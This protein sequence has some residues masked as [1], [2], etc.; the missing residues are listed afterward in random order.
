MARRS[1]PRLSPAQ[2]EGKE[3]TLAAAV[4]RWLEG[5][6]W[7]VYQEVQLALP[8][9]T[10]DRVADIIALKGD[11]VWGIECKV[12]LTLPLLYQA[13][14][15]PTGAV[16]IAIPHGRQDSKRLFGMQAA[17][18]LAH[19]GVLAVTSQG[20]VRVALGAVPRPSSQDAAVRALLR[21]E[22]KTHAKA[23][24]AGGGF[25]TPYKDTISKIRALLAEHGPLTVP[26]MVKLMGKGHYKS[27]ASARGALAKALP[28]FERDTIVPAGLGRF[29]LRG[30]AP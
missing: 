24:T 7:D 13:A 11:V 29:A 12:N 22:H 21:P 18:I 19:A 25:W 28:A 9:R 4:V 5:Q 8:D 17:Q 30:G 14:S 3:A 26:E 15:L 16:A 20:D 27:P 23:G 1:S 10:I 2:K 6:G